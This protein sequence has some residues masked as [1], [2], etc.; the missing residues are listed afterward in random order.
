MSD[1]T[2]MTREGHAKIKQQVVDM[3][4]KAPAL[5]LAIDEA[6]Q[7][8]DLSENAAYHAAREELAKLEAN[9]ARLQG[10]LATADII[11]RGK[12]AAA[13]AAGKIVFGSSVQVRDLD[14]DET[15]TYHLVGPGEVDVLENRI[16][17]TSP[18]GQALIGRAV[19]DAVDIQVP[20][21]KLHYKIEEIS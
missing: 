18:V 8:G 4:A 19:G 11:D 20:Q 12:S 1:T 21:G 3:K 5:R 7:Q 15:E 10:Q 6:R 16:L 17:T 13:G 14:S 9:I 2:P